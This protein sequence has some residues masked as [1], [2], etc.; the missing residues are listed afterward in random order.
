MLG[1]IPYIATCPNVFDKQQT[2][3]WLNG[4]MSQEEDE[5]LD[6]EMTNHMIAFTRTVKT[7]NNQ[8]K[9]NK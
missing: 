2:D 5:E 8:Q 3:L 1:A 6:R 9:K 7:R 4:H